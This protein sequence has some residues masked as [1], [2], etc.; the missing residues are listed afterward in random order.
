V[1]SQLLA[2]RIESDRA[3][4]ARIEVTADARR[5]VSCTVQAEDRTREPVGV[6][7]LTVP[8][9]TDA[10]RRAATKVSTRAR[11]VTVVLVGCRLARG[12]KG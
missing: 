5:A 11:A 10:T 6:R 8:A 7:R 12:S 2:F 4:S 1:R 3:V 9:G